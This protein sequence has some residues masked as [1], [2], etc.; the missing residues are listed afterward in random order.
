MGEYFHSATFI[1]CSNDWYQLLSKW[2]FLGVLLKHAPNGA[3]KA[4]QG[5][6][7]R[8]AIGTPSNAVRRLL[9]QSCHRR[10]RLARAPELRSCPRAVYCQTHPR[11]T[12]L[13]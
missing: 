4:L 8:M 13:A 9:L 5:L 3:A 7:R 10:M 6:G 11:S 12:L 2:N 1:K